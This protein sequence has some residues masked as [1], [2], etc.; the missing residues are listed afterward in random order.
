MSKETALLSNLALSLSLSRLSFLGKQKRQLSLSFLN[1]TWSLIPRAGSW[2]A[3]HN[4]R[5]NRIY[6][7]SSLSVSPFKIVGTMSLDRNY[8]TEVTNL[9]FVSPG[10]YLYETEV[11]LWRQE[12]L[13][14][15]GA[16]KKKRRKRKNARRPARKV[17]QTHKDETCCDTPAVPHSLPIPP[18]PDD[19]ASRAI[20]PSSRPC[21][22]SFV[23]DTIEKRRVADSAN[24]TDT[25][26]RG[27]AASSE[28]HGIEKRI[29]S[30]QVSLSFRLTGA[31]ENGEIGKS[32]SFETWLPATFTIA[33][34]F[35]DE[36]VSKQSDG[37]QRGGA[38]GGGERR[39]KKENRPWIDGSEAHTRV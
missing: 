16:K 7:N 12:I 8:Y 17:Q 5:L 3:D 26:T 21:Q 19:V 23:I 1:Y 15:H 38:E 36:I 28:K 25:H 32:L 39:E 9:S 24:T 22:I 20:S 11:K 18:P 30:A 35:R 27:L 2:F 13:D 31:L 4:E 10:L 33:A 34:R 6:N 29:Q 14:V 37:V